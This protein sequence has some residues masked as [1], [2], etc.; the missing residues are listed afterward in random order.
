MV[1]ISASDGI[2]VLAMV[3]SSYSMKDAMASA[4]GISDL[5]LLVP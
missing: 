4:H 1:S 3:E 5:L 2:V